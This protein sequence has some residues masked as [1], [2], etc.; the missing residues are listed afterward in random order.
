M[1]Y[2]GPDGDQ[3]IYFYEGTPTGAY[4]KWDSTLNR[5]VFSHPIDGSISDADKLDGQHGSYYLDRANHTGIQPRSTISDFAHKDTHKTGGSDA[6]TS[7]DTI[8]ALV[9]RIQAQGSVNLEIGTIGDGQFLKRSSGSIVGSSIAVGDLPAH[10]NTH[11][12][13]GSDAFT[14]TDII[15]ALVRRIRES[16]GTNLQI[17]TVADQQVLMRVGTDIYGYYIKN[18]IVFYEDGTLTVKTK[19]GMPATIIVPF[20]CTVIEVYGYVET[21]PT[22]SAIIVDVNLNGTSI[23]NTNPSNRLT[24]NAGS[25]TGSSTTFDT[26]NFSKN[27]RL[28]IDIDQV[29]SGTAGEDLSVCIR[30]RPREVAVP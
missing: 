15:D 30:I 21:A 26:S 20:N 19:A 28:T 11:V 17:Q 18:Q 2:N 7:T 13:G 27:D 12:S 9:K 1:K 6:F 5:F 14:S 24:I 29:G 3:Y 8:E 22:G 23:W 25:Q 10:K 4:I 16:G